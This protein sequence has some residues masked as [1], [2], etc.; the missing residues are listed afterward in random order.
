M[1]EVKAKVKAREAKRTAARNAFKP[2]ANGARASSGAVKSGLFSSKS[3]GASAAAKIRA[4]EKEKDTESEEG[5]Q[6][7]GVVKKRRE[8]E[9]KKGKRVVEMGS[10]DEEASEGERERAALEMEAAERERADRER[11]E[12]RKEVEDL[13]RQHE[14]EDEEPQ[15]PEI[16]DLDEE[17]VKREVEVEEKMSVKKSPEKRKLN[18]AFGLPEV[19]RPRRIR[20]E[21]EET[22]L[23]EDGYLHTRRVVKVT[24][25]HGNEVVEDNGDRR[26]EQNEKR[27]GDVETPAKGSFPTPLKPTS[28]EGG[29]TMGSMKREKMK[30]VKRSASKPGSSTPKKTPKKKIKGNIMSYFGKKS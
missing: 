1:A 30:D 10:D 24:D 15:S 4:V 25:E 23:G 14:D 27:N 17:A 13:T 29:K 11:E 2:L 26:V 12:L 6:R 18:E 7:N 5:Q 22:V 20:R 3:L 21:V 8:S 16:R 19:S 9:G 28:S